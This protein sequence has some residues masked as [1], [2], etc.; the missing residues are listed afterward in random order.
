MTRD[1]AIIQAQVGAILDNW[2][3]YVWH[4]DIADYWHALKLTRNTEQILPRGREI[5]IVSPEG[6]FPLV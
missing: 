3:W 5:I 2:P 1:E 6:V 4:D